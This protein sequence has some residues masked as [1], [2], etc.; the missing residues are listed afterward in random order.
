[1]VPPAPVAFST[2]KL[3]FGMYLR[4][5]SASWRATRS[6]GPPAAK[7]TTKVMGLVG[8][9]WA[10]APTDK[11]APRARVTNFFMACLRRKLEQGSGHASGDPGIANRGKHVA[12]PSGKTRKPSGRWRA[13]R[14]SGA[15]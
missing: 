7:G 10:K 11:A 2:T 3:E 9:D 5:V 12:K 6:V 4:M 14:L 1:M 8:K 15:A 13:V